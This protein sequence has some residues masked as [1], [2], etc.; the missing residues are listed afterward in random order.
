MSS[1]KA[2]LPYVVLSNHSPTG[3]SEGIGVGVSVG[4]GVGGG[5]AV[6]DGI[7]DGVAWLAGLLAP[8]AVRSISRSIMHIGSRWHMLRSWLVIVCSSHALPLVDIRYAARESRRAPLLPHAL[9]ELLACSHRRPA[10]HRPNALPRKPS[11]CHQHS[12][13]SCQTSLESYHSSS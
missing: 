1:T 6:A 13:E 4:K 9:R 2:T 5:V 10:T 7:G 12:R 3:G 11:Y 8:H